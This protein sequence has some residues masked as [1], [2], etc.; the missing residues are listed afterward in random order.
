MINNELPGYPNIFVNC[1]D[2][3]DV[4]KAHIRGMERPAAANKR[5]ILAEEK[6]ITMLGLAT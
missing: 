2:I 4:T 6:G 3:M 5:F 1:V